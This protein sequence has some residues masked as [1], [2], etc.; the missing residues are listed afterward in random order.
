MT[1]FWILLSGFFIA[2]LL[3]FIAILNSSYLEYVNPKFL[4]H[5][6]D[7]DK[8]EELESVLLKSFQKHIQRFFKN[9]GKE[10]DKDNYSEKIDL[11]LAN[12]VF[13]NSTSD[14][15]S[16]DAKIGNLNL[17]EMLRDY[18]P[19]KIT[20]SSKLSMFL[21]KDK[22]FIYIVKVSNERESPH[23]FDSKAGEIS[24]YYI[25]V[26]NF[27]LDPSESGKMENSLIKKCWSSKFYGRIIGAVSSNDKFNLGVFYRLV[28]GPNI[29]YRIRFF[30]NI[31]CNNFE[32]ERTDEEMEQKYA[33]YLKRR[34]DNYHLKDYFNEVS[35]DDFSLKGNTPVSSMTIKKDVIA[36]S[37]DFDY[38]QFYIL[39]REKNPLAWKVSLIGPPINKTVHNLFHTNSLKFAND[40]IHDYKLLHI[41]VTMNVSGINTYG[42]VVKANHTD[43]SGFDHST[44]STPNVD[45]DINSDEIPLDYSLRRVAKYSIETEVLNLNKYEDFNIDTSIQKLK[46]FMKPTV[47]SNTN[48]P[49]NLLF[50][51]KSGTVCIMGWSKKTNSEY[52]FNLT[53]DGEDKVSKISADE[54]N[55]NII[56]VSLS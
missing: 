6:Y 2:N 23:R 32:I 24:L 1:S 25:P 33:E 14:S 38:R 34:G 12:E 42:Y 53:P 52:F 17:N 5:S 30:H 18:Q 11:N 51:F 43:Y 8:N 36:Y 10:R 29:N 54:N 47:F 22:Q 13:T 49:N 44:N 35:Y 41:Y 15:N 50:E 45:S 40:N 48:H 3:W 9:P 19:L 37:R 55:E 7:V 20:N 46:R 26:H 21:D 56:I 4:A 27:I 39:R 28:K 31:S 16:E